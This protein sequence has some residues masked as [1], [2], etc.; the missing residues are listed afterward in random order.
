MLLSKTTY[1][2][3]DLVD[4]LRRS[5]LRPGDIVLF[6]VSH[7]MLGQ[8]ECGSSGKQVCELLYSAM[9]EVIGPDG[10][11]LLPAFSFSFCKNED[12]D[13]QST[14]CMEGTWSSSLEFLEY[15]RCL[16]GVFRSADPILSVTG[17]GPGAEKLLT[18][19]PNTS[20]GKDCLYE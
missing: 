2:R 1:S 8:V 10:T 17:L 20:Y 5:G 18:S 3:T 12:Y 15:F 11:M 6:H 13:P 14:P 19:L 16:P 4:G 7:L 9:R